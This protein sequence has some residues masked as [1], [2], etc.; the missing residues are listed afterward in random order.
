MEE[1]VNIVTGVGV[2]ELRGRD[3]LS[4]RGRVAPM[5]IVQRAGTAGRE[6][7]CRTGAEFASLWRG[8]VRRAYTRDRAAERDTQATGWLVAEGTTSWQ[9][10]ATGAEWRGWTLDHGE[11]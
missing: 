5:C 6:R 3:R 10:G 4:D 7:Q 2:V 1:I 9:I 11:I 8:G